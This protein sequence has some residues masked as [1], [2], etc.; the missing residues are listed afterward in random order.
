MQKK[1]RFCKVN[2]SGL[3]ICEWIQLTRKN[4]A[5]SNNFLIATITCVWLLLDVLLV[6]SLWLSLQLLFYRRT[7][8]CATDGFGE[9]HAGTP[10]LQ[11][12]HPRSFLLSFPL[13]SMNFV[14]FLPTSSAGSPTNWCL[15]KKHWH[16]FALLQSVLSFS[17]VLETVQILS[18]CVT[19]DSPTHSPN[20]KHWWEGELPDNCSHHK[21]QR[22]KARTRENNKCYLYVFYL[23]CSFTGVP[24]ALM[25]TAVPGR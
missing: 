9:L 16:G 2:I 7:W 23:R 6:Y 17:L 24:R 19:G 11:C 15:N 5:D 13:P 14:I 8:G 12:V 22:Q 25:N 18:S 3:L 10:L 1:L 21:C 20:V 4:F